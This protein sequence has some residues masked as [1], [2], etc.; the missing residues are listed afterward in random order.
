[1]AIVKLQVVSWLARAFDAENSTRFQTELEVEA[2]TTV[3]TLFDK[4]AAEYEGFAQYAFD[5]DR[6]DL[7]GRVSVFFNDRVLELVR[8]LDTQISDGD[9][10]L[11]LPAYAGGGLILQGKACINQESQRGGR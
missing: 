5:R 2:G 11:V 9:T 8:G 3:R 1:M 6:Q 7:T 10:I 4:L